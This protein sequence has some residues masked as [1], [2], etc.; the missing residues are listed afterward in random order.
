MDG[1]SQ[2]SGRTTNRFLSRSSMSPVIKIAANAAIPAMTRTMKCPELVR[3]TV[4]WEMWSQT[5][6]LLKTG[7]MLSRFGKSM[8]ETWKKTTRRKICVG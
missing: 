4:A 1:K 3:A 5:S 6:S 2:A 8:E 7:A